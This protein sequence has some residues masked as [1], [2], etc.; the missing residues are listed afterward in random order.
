MEMDAWM[1]LQLVND[2]M[3]QM[4]TMEESIAERFHDE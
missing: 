1:N 2:E 4:K 3:N